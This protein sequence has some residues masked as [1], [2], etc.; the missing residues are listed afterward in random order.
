MTITKAIVRKGKEGKGRKEEIWLRRKRLNGLKE[1][2]L[3]NK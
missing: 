3:S 2:V 1:Y